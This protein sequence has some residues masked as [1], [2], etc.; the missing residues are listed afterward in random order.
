MLKFTLKKKKSYFKI[1]N[2]EL[3]FINNVEEDN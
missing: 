3:S 2:I 1:V